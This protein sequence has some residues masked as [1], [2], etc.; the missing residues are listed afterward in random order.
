MAVNHVYVDP[1][2]SGNDGDSGFTDGSFA[3]ATLTLTKVGAFTNAVADHQLYLTDNGSG[4]VTAGMYRITSVTDNDNVVLHAD[5]RSGASDPTD[6]V[7]IL[8]DGSSSLPWASM[9]AAVDFITDGGAGN[10]IN[11]KA[12]TADVLAT[13]I[14][15]TNYSPTNAIANPLV[16]RGYTSAAD[17]DGI[18]EI[19]GNNAVD[20]TFVYHI[21]ARYTY[22]IDLKLHNTTSEVLKSHLDCAVLRCEIYDGGTSA[23]TSIAA[24]SRMIG[25]NL[26]TGGVG[27]RA[28]DSSASDSLFLANRVTSHSDTAFFFVA[29][30]NYAIANLIHDVGD[31][32][33]QFGSGDQHVGYANTVTGDNS[34]GEWGFFVNAGSHANIILSNIIKDFGSGTGG[35]IHF[36]GSDSALV[37]G[38]NNMHGNAADVD[39]KL[40]F[41]LDLT[42]FDT[43]TDPT[44]TD[45]AGDDYSV[46]DN[47]RADGY[48]T[49]WPGTSTNTNVDVGCAQ[50]QES[51]GGF[52]DKGL[53]KS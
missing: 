3:N 13:S 45:A 6:V 43:T 34:A 50:R 23:T 47:A 16:I 46:G 31:H 8:H 53:V 25:C 42:A 5:I 9:H 17:D 12:G 24:R 32:G 15:W 19:D 44:F 49:T 26:H 4:E 18:G 22:F 37:L 14:D 33:I 10:Q 39:G 40:V 27:A 48:P 41:G 21:T 38:Y 7:N 52:V 1:S 35:A 29:H 30:R 28:V 20:R 11:L 36:D 51:S 2:S